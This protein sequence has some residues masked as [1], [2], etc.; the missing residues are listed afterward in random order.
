MQVHIIFAEIKNLYLASIIISNKFGSSLFDLCLK[1]LSVSKH[2]FTYSIKILWLGNWK[3]FFKTWKMLLFFF[4]PLSIPSS[5]QLRN[6]IDWNFFTCTSILSTVD[7]VFLCY[8]V[9]LKAPSYKNMQTLLVI[10][11]LCLTLPFNSL[12]DLLKEIKMKL[13]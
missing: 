2:F 5:V 10:F 13:V 4:W 1:S 6:K 9:V 7:S 8:G 12:D 3:S 11:F